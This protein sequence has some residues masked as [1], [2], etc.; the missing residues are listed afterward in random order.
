[1]EVGKLGR[2]EPGRQTGFSGPA[3][4]YDDGFSAIAAIQNGDV[5]RGRV[6]VVR[7]MGLKGGPGMAGPASMVLFAVDAAGVA[8]DVAFVTDGH[9]SPHCLPRSPLAPLYL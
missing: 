8:G 4:V 6:L 7:G 3:V 2:P 9:L 1:S 5:E